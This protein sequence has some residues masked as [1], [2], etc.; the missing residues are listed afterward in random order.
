MNDDAIANKFPHASRCY[1]LGVSI[2][3]LILCPAKNSACTRG[4]KCEC[5]RSYILFLWRCVHVNNA[6]TILIASRPAL[7]VF[8]NIMIIIMIGYGG[9]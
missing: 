8:C 5:V 6:V 1:T 4:G 3:S 2:T 9:K 7:F